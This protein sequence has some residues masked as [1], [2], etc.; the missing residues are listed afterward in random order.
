[1]TVN[2]EPSS[3][4]LNGYREGLAP[5]VITADLKVLL[6]TAAFPAG[7]ATMAFRRI[8]PSMIQ[9]TWLRMMAVCSGLFDEQARHAGRVPA[10]TGGVAGRTGFGTPHSGHDGS[11][12]S[13]SQG[14]RVRQD[15]KPWLQ[16]LPRVVAE[17]KYTPTRGSGACAGALQAF[18]SCYKPCKGDTIEENS[19]V[20][21]PGQDPGSLHLQHQE[22]PAC[23]VGCG[24]PAALAVFGGRT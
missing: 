11:R 22:S 12:L 20:S 7:V 10:K 24:P 5:T 19:H 3:I 16:V 14:P 17:A 2:G 15:R 1:M 8:L 6:T 18:Y 13:G 4:S 23:P 9:K 21:I